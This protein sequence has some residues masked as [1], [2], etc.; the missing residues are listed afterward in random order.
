LLIARAWPLREAEELA[1]SGELANAVRGAIN[2]ALTVIGE[3]PL[4]S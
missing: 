4:Q 1:R 2:H 3:R